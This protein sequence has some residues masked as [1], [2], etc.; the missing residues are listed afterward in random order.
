M[1]IKALAENTSV[2]SDFGC[3]HGLSLYIETPN[4]KILFD[5]GCE[6]GLFAKNALLLGVDLRQ[7]DIAFISHGHFDHGGGLKTF[8]SLN[9]KA[10]VYV[11]HKAFDKHFANFENGGIKSVGLDATLQQSGRFVHVGE[12]L[13]ID[14]E[15][16]LFSNVRCLKLNP[17][18]NADL[19]KMDGDKTVPDDFTHEQNLVIRENGQ[20]VLVSGCSHCGIVNI[21]EHFYQQNGS[22]PHTVIGGFHLFNP[23]RDQHER[24]EIVREI[25]AFLLQTNARFYTC[26]CTGLESYKLLKDVMGDSIGYLS[27]GMTLAL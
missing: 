27:G 23:A 25:G 22:Y 15:L 7:V 21:L 8:L 2:N 1:I 19:L 9:D 18:G 10:K 13:Q 5:T 20:T 16:A 26:H 24:P 4:H 12:Q 3:E 6:G 17:T 11:S 14:D